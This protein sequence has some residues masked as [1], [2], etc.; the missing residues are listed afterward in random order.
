MDAVCP[1]VGQCLLYFKFALC[2]HGLQR[3]PYI[4]VSRLSWRSYH[5][6]ASYLVPLEFLY[7][8]RRVCKIINFDS[9]RDLALERELQ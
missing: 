7:D 9:R 5:F 2:F 6:A 1:R 3:C 4:L 8:L